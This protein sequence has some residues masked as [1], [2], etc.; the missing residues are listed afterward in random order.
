MKSTFTLRKPLSLAAGVALAAMLAPATTFAE[1]VE[2]DAELTIA[3]INLWRGAN[4]S[5]G[6][7]LIGE[8]EVETE[9][10]LFAGLEVGNTLEN[11]APAEVAISVG[12]EREFGE[13][14]FG[15][16]YTEYTYPGAFGDCDEDP[17]TPDEKCSWM[18][19]N[20][21]EYFL[22]LGYADFSVAAYIGTDSDEE[23]KYY[24]LDYDTDKFGVHVGMKDHA[25]TEETYTDYNVRYNFTEELAMTVSVAS[26]DAVDDPASEMTEGP[27]FV[28]SYTVP[29]GGE[30]E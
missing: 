28:F 9:F 15:L 21:S 18:D 26:G 7:A 17:L 10:G 22:S 11:D 24:S 4:T 25:M 8:A 30:K 27:L 14:G 16:G 2:V 29:V 3:T 12:Y 20:E 13:F 23:A 5:G 19:M 1:G 6:A